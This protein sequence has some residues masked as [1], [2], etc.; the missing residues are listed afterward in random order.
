MS[1]V[2]EVYPHLS[3]YCFIVSY[4]NALKSFSFPI[5]FVCLIDDKKAFWNILRYNSLGHDLIIQI[6]DHLI[7]VGLITLLKEYLK[8]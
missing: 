5:I 1:Q 8:G 6:F 2:T 7:A 4:H 3:M